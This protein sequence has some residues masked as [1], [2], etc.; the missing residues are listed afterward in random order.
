MS[1]LVVGAGPAGCATAL[2][3]ARRGVEVVLI[4]RGRF[5]RDKVC[6]DVL[7][8]EAQQA[9]A[10]LGLDLAPL[11]A[12]CHRIDRCRYH[13]PSGLCVELPFCDRHGESRPWWVV[14]RRDFDG[15]L[16]AQ[17]CAAGAGLC[18]GVSAVD[19]VIRDA[20]VAG[21][22]V[23]DDGG[24]RREIA[25]AA[26]VGADGAS[27][28]LARAL[29]RFERP[30]AHLC[31]AV[32]GY[33][34]SPHGDDPVFD[35]YTSAR[36][37]PGCAWHVPTGDGCAN[38][39]LGVLRSDLDRQRIGARALLDEVAGRYP[40]LAQRLAAATGVVGWSLPGA[41]LPLSRSTAGALLV[42]DAGCMVDPWT[43]HGI[44]TALIAGSL[45]ADVVADALAAGEVGA[46]A[47]GRFDRLWQQ[48]FGLE[49][50]LGWLLQRFC[51]SP[52]RVEAMLALAARSERR[53]QI[54]GGLIGHAYPRQRWLDPQ[55]G[56][57]FAIGR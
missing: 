17:A 7:L 38:V 48:R 55:L 40:E 15:W 18:E 3:L 16:V 45:A 4:E 57:R 8:P 32:R 5:P 14:K 39:G 50:K 28:T 51:A 10:D 46:G 2:G 36:T 9:L 30:A 27:S 54:I 43:G 19:L 11:A 13:A 49:M 47:L 22:V 41:S 56:L 26:V 42:G 23:R 20:A 37:L 35:I 29:G 12:R 6:G 33:A 25:A 31:V 53:R 34:P 24:A 44:H 21:V 1:V 52:G